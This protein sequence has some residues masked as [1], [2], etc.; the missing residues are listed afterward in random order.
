MAYLLGSATEASIGRIS[1]LKALNRAMSA[2]ELASLY[3]SGVESAEMA[4][5]NTPEYIFDFLNTD[6][7][8]TGVS[9]A[10]VTAVDGI[11]SRDDVLKIESNG[12]SSTRARRVNIGNHLFLNTK[13]TIM[14][15]IPSGNVT[16]TGFRVALTE[17]GTDAIEVSEAYQLSETDTWESFE[18][19]ILALATEDST[20]RIA[21]YPITDSGGITVTSGDIVYVDDL[22][23]YKCGQTANLGANNIQLA[24]GQWIE[25]ENNAHAIIPDDARVI[26]AKQSGVLKGGTTFTASAVGQHICGAD[27]VVLPDNV[28]VTMNMKATVSASFDIGDGVDQDYYAAAVTIGTEWGEVSLLKKFH[29]GTNK[30]IVLTPVSTYTG[31]VTSAVRVDKL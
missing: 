14:A 18:S 6:G 24:A 5:S 16:C 10:T 26:E 20:R 2:A 21:I 1:S 29:D 4:A 25:T 13:F 22:S 23:L 30:K 7:V 31:V 27:A 12:S 15:A 3:A 17:P 11:F 19:G 9:G 8:F 28:K